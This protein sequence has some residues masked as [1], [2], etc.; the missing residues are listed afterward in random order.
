LLKVEFQSKGK[1]RKGTIS[2]SEEKR[3]LHLVGGIVVQIGKIW[4]E[5]RS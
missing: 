2:I 3:L 1:Q 4:E 5:R